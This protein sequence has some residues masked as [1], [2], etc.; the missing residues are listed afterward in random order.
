ME[1]GYSIFSNAIDTQMAV[2]V[3]V[4]FGYDLIQ[5]GIGILLQPLLAFAR[6]QLDHDS[7]TFFFGD[8]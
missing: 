4:I 7:V 2:S 8:E 5:R 3:S 6:L 1:A